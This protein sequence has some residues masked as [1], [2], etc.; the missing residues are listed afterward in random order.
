[1]R[2]WLRRRMKV[3]ELVIEDPKLVEV[4][5]EKVVIAKE[6]LKEARSRQKDFTDRHRRALEF[7][8]EDHVFLKQIKGQDYVAWR[9][10]KIEGPGLI[11]D[12]RPRVLEASHLSYIRRTPHSPQDV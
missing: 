4:T 10:I 11:E 12:E 5:N 6:N 7:K 1:V 2:N 9:I 8:P 3:G